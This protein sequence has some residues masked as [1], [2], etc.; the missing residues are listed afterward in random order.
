MN[1]IVISK[2]E[3]VFPDGV[4]EAFRRIAA[5]YI[6]DL[7]AQDNS[8]ILSEL[9]GTHFVPYA[10]V[11]A[12]E[13]D[14]FLSP[15]N[16]DNIVNRAIN[17]VI[18]PSETMICV[19]TEPPKGGPIDAFILETERCS[20]DFLRFVRY[21]LDDVEDEEDGYVPPYEVSRY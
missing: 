12:E 5:H 13:Y 1:E 8:M 3:A 17:M 21:I 10:L 6:R 18:D 20:I 2:G 19:F 11:N 7:L 9:G 4:S 16:P 15:N 14:R